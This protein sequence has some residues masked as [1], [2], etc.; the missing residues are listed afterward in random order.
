MSVEGGRGE[1]E[2]VGEGGDCLWVRTCVCVWGSVSVGVCL[3]AVS[4]TVCVHGLSLGIYS[5]L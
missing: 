4:M 2:G 5:Y 1:L 3:L